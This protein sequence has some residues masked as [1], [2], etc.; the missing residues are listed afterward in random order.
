MKI[1]YWAILLCA[2]VNVLLGMLWFGAFREPWMSGHDLTPEGLSSME[3]PM[4]PH[5]V[6]ILTAI[7][8]AYIMSMIF[9]RMCVCTLRDG[10]LTGA[11]F[12]VFGLLGTIVLNLYAMRPFS[13]SL[14][15]GGFAFVQML[16]FGAIL[17]AWIKK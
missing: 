12:G 4:L 16:I 7:V 6:S 9:R 3:N 13:L 5:L 17:G 1:N 2:I 15:D 10:L 8:I 14:V 11:G